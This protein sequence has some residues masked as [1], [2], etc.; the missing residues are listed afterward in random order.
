MNC[1]SVVSHGNV[2][3]CEFWKAAKI[4][5]DNA[6]V[7][8]RRILTAKK[9]LFLQLNADIQSMCSSEWFE[10]LASVA[11]L[12]KNCPA[13]SKTDHSL[14]LELEASCSEFLSDG[15][16]DPLNNG[17]YVC[18]QKLLPR[19]PEKFSHTLNLAIIDKANGRITFFSHSIEESKQSL[20]PKWSYRLEHDAV[21]CKLSLYVDGNENV[22]KDSSFKWLK[23]QFFPR[24]VKWANSDSPGS[25]LISGSLNLISAE[26]YAIL[27]NKLKL[28]Y[29]TAMVKIWPENTDSAKF[30]YEDVA[31]ATYLLLI[32][33]MERTRKNVQEKQSFVDLG[34][35]NGLLVHI[36]ASEGHPGLGI[37]LRKR[38]IWDLYPKSTRLEVRTIVPSASSLFPETD[39]LIGNHSDELTPWIPVI[40]ARSSHQCQFF[41]LPCCAYEFNG[42]KYQRD[43]AAKSQYFEYMNYI[44]NVCEECGFKTDMD[45]LRIPSTK[46]ICL[47]G[48][49]RIYTK[50]RT[51]VQEAAIRELIDARSNGRKDNITDSSDPS[52]QNLWSAGFKPRENVERVR[53]CTKINKGIISDI[54]NLVAE[55]LLCKVRMID[56]QS[57]NEKWNAGGQI[58]LSEVAQLL[59]Q[60]ALKEMKSE[61]GGV[62]T[63]LK[64][65]SDI[66]Q[67]I[68]GKVQ[69]RVPGTCTDVTR[70]KN[71]RNNSK[72]AK[73]TKPCWFHLNHPNGCPLNEEICYYKH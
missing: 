6:H 61:C 55:R 43:N 25:S 38:G 73:K 13:P 37:D 35:G 40:A 54:V 63:L 56:I 39:W 65:N 8:N 66:F 60:E 32:W 49:D 12:Y 18:L 62:Q 10:K 51:D 30:V 48:R 1:E 33:E 9:L 31:I 36:L 24:F 69:F 46:R 58:E 59:S 67:V 47:I 70:K 57:S 7:V 53:N 23:D 20:G 5:L 42:R 28:K 68:Q 64:N 41:L 27:Y 4:W 45:K 11:Q 16:D 2:D 72:F 15:L 17:S 22:C 3:T 19:N 14:A 44:K 52:D 50:D 26:K 34:C 71:K 29:G 21:L